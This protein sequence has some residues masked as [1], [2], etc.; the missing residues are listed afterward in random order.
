VYLCTHK[1]IYTQICFESLLKLTPLSSSGSFA[2][3]YLDI[4]RS[5]GLTRQEEVTKMY[6]GGLQRVAKLTVTE[7]ENQKKQADARNIIREQKKVNDN[8]SRDT[9]AEAIASSKSI[10]AV[11]TPPT[12][13]E[14]PLSVER[15]RDTQKSAQVSIRSNYYT[16]H[17]GIDL[18]HGINVDQ[19]SKLR[20]VQK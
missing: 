11:S 14:L 3:A 1:C 8:D 20:Q 9:K 6:T 18:D 10:L 17:R 15:E 16:S 7:Y 12:V 19:H 2:A 5:S 4:L 13:F